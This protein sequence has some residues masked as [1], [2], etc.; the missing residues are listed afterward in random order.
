MMRRHRTLL[1][2]SLR[3][4][5]SYLPSKSSNL[6]ISLEAATAKRA[7]IDNDDYDPYAELDEYVGSDDE[8][9]GANNQTSVC[10][11]LS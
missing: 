11:R 10:R 9:E 8:A 4:K 7:L 3:K 2:R 6:I 5:V 1:K